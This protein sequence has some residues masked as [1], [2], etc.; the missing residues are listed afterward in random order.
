MYLKELCITPCFTNS[1][2][3]II[4]FVRVAQN[5]IHDILLKD[6]LNTKNTPI[7][8]LDNIIVQS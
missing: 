8:L 3:I 1:L 6:L 2:K 4:Q 7:H 5:K